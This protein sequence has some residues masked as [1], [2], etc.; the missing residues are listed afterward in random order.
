MGCENFVA[1]PIFFE[2]FLSKKFLA[3]AYIEIIGYRIKNWPHEKSKSV[4]TE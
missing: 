1:L 2:Q 3:R 4:I